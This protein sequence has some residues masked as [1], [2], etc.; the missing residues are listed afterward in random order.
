LIRDDVREFDGRS[1]DNLAD[2]W[3]QLVETRSKFH[4]STRAAGFKSGRAGSRS[5]SRWALET[6]FVSQI[7]KG[8]KKTKMVEEIFDGEAEEN[9]LFL[10]KF[11]QLHKRWAPPL[12]ARR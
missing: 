9:E 1:M 6:G 5:L 8:A 3:Q 2:A 4:S 11:M 7:V 12:R 10:D